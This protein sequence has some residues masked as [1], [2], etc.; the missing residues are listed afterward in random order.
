MAELTAVEKLKKWV[1]DNLQ[2]L[3]AAKVETIVGEYSGDGDEGNWQSTSFEPE[4]AAE[5]LDEELRDEVGELME[6]AGQELES[7]GYETGDDGGGGSITLVVA[8]GQL[9]HSEYYFETT[10]TYTAEDAVV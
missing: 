1:E 10:R 3:Q 9:L 8:T 5:N 2:T 7:P 4:T 6:N